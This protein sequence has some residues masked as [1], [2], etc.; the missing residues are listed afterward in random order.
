MKHVPRTKLLSRSAGA[1]ALARRLRSDQRGVA[2]IEFAIFSLFL[3]LAI[4][5]V[6]DVS[7]YIY[8]RMQLENATQSAVQAALKTCD[9][10]S[11]PATTNC[12]G[13]NAA[14]QTAIAT[15]SLG[16]N[17]SQV[18]GSPSEGYYCLNSSNALQFM[19]DVSSKP[20]DCSAAGKPGVQPGDYIHITASF[21]Y[22]PL[23]PGLSIASQLAT[24]ITTTATMRLG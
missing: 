13:L 17:V 15:T 8:Q 6:T 14:I 5:N 23:F 3:F 19:S 24:P 7:V 12:A 2:A 1:F 16:T 18:T 22:A 9:L 21:S 11:L 4:A 10:N 20:A